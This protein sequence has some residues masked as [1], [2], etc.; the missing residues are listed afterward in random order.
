MKTIF[1]IF[2]IIFQLLSC[3]RDKNPVNP[4][5]NLDGEGKMILKTEKNI[6]SWQQSESIFTITIEGTLQNIST[7]TYYSHIGDGY[8]PSEQ[9]FLLFVK[10]SAG[11]IEK[12]NEL[13]TSWTETD[14]LG[15]LIEG[16]KTIPIKPAKNYTFYA[17]LNRRSDE[18]EI[19]K[20]RLRIEYHDNF[21]LKNNEM[22]YRDY[23]NVFE[24]K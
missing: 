7:N 15:L 8:G 11:W 18:I 20:Y 12:Y 21:D 22:I 13:D 10:Y 6:Y 16:S 2:T 4:P 23:S 1:F 14:L 24:I 9:D 19:G 17:H 5:S 3:T